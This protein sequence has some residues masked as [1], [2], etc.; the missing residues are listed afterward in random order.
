MLHTRIAIRGAVLP[1][2][3]LLALDLTAQN[4]SVRS[5]EESDA[6]FGQL[7]GLTE[8]DRSFTVFPIRDRG[9]TGWWG[10]YPVEFDATNQSRFRSGY[11]DGYRIPGAGLGTRVSAGAYVDF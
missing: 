5:V 2:L 1:A 10:L 8:D 9:A 3:L 6:R 11:N 4:L 7:G